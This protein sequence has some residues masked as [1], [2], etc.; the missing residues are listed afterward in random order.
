MEEFLDG[1]RPGEEE[2]MLDLRNVDV[3]REEEGLRGRETS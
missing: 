3:P 2:R 1:E